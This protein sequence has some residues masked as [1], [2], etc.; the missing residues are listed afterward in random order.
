MSITLALQTALSGIQAQQSALQVTANNIANVNTVGYTRKVVDFQSR[1]L[2]NE[3]AGV[4]VGTISR[5][6]DEFLISQLRDQESVVGELSVRD[7]FL[8]IVQGFF[9]PP[10]S[11]T[12]LTGGI[13]E[14]NTALET[15]AVS[16]ETASSRFNAVNEARTLAAQFQSLSDLVQ[17][18][19]LDAELDIDQ[20]VVRVD[21]KLKEVADLNLKIARAAAQ[22]EPTGDLRDQRDRALA[23]IAEEMDIQA[24]ET[25]DSQVVIFTGKGRTL[26]T[27]AVPQDITHNA[28]AQMSPSIYYT[29]PSDPDYPGVVTG[30]FVGPPAVDGRNDITNDIINGR[31]KGLIELR[32]ETL[33]NLQKEIDTLG[34]TLMN[35][36]N[37]LHNKGTAQPPPNSLTGTHSFTSTDV[38]SATGNVRVALLN[39]SDGTVVSSTDIALGGFTTVNDAVSA[40]DGITGISASL[41][42]N[43]KLVVSADSASQGIAINEL[44]S[45]ATVIG[46][47]TRGFSHY[48]G[49]NDFFV[50]PTD[51]TQYDDFLSAKQASS[52]SQLGITGTLTFAGA[53]GSTT[54]GYATSDSLEGLAANINANATLTAANT[55]ATVFSDGGSRRL[56]ISD[57]EGNNTLITD[58]GSFLSSFQLAPEETSVARV[59]AVNSAI[60]NNPD[61]IARGTLSSGALVAGDDGITVGDATNA[62][63]LA[64]LFSDDQSFR[65]TGGIAATTT[66]FT[67]FASQVLSLQASLASNAK[68]DFAFQEEFQL[69]LNSRASAQ[70]GVNIDEELS[71][72]VLLEQ[73]FSAAARVA[74]VAADLLQVLLDE[75]R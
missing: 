24:I 21:T 58:T 34:N 61:L 63:T 52:S 26:L 66:T 51:V 9:G 4:E 57:A 18:L 65:S 32:D 69:T 35:N 40:I 53:F 47:E 3:G 64:G 50:A 12:T 56:R 72:L 10:N 6:V 46:S 22:N 74:Q 33:P 23:A 27:L 48:F 75:V 2:V 68:T 8:S 43:G 55:T 59:L 36:F 70:S 38:L 42:T 5:K 45:A 7:R 17:E 44:T 13:S 14:F 16:P 73:A 39:Q 29:D 15:L 71:N 30:I 20:A 62:N 31:L 19:R 67:R 60:V 1:T 49:L 37:A 28:V 41:D 11:A 25:A 54:V